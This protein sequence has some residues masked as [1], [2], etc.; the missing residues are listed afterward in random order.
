MNIINININ[1]NINYI[2][3]NNM[4]ELD[5]LDFSKLSLNNIN[6][7][8]CDHMFLDIV[9]F[10]KYDNMNM[11]NI[12]TSSIELKFNICLSCNYI[13]TSYTTYHNDNIEETF[14]DEEM[15]S[16]DTFIENIINKIYEEFITKDEIKITISNLLNIL[17]RNSS[18]YSHY[19]DELLSNL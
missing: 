18:S 10:N 2:N 1:I 3:N 13:Y 12:I 19:I 16:I 7:E 14:C 5:M 9:V 6:V 11:Y 15:I 8:E 4:N 17:I